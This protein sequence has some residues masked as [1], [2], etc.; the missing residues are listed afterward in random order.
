[1]FPAC[2]Y[3]L[4]SLGQVDMVVYS[5]DP[6]QWD[7]VTVSFVRSPILA[8]QFDLIFTFD[9]FDGADMFTIRSQDIHLLLDL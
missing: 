2:E 5:H 9:L 6:T 1:M 7:E 3:F 8:C 4:A